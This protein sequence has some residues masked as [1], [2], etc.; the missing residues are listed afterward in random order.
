MGVVWVVG[1]EVTGGGGWKGGVE[2]WRDGLSVE[3]G[4]ETV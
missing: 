2:G 1:R 3:I 4:K